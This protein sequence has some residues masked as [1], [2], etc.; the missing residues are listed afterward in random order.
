MLGLPRQ[1][2]SL[3]KQR[4]MENWRVVIEPRSLGN[5]G[6]ASMSDQVIEPDEMKRNHRYRDACDSLV[7][8]VKRHIDGVESVYVD[9]DTNHTCDHCGYCW[10]GKNSDYNGGCCEKDQEEED[11]RNAKAKA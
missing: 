5:L 2:R 10:S 6:F 4:K 11:A 1:R 9:C 7:R 3:S 8:E